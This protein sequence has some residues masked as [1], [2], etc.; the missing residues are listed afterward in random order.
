LD[1]EEGLVM[2]DEWSR[3]GRTEERRLRGTVVTVLPKAAAGVKVEQ[4]RC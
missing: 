2:V 1:E 4:Q 3:K